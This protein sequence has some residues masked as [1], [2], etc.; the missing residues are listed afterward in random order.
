MALL[1]KKRFFLL[2]ALILAVCL[3]LLSWD[4]SLPRQTLFIEEAALKI[5][6]LPLRTISLFTRKAGSLV[7][8][9]V[10]LVDLGQENGVLREEARNL[11][12]DNRLLRIEAR[13]NDH[14]RGLL[15]LKDR[16]PA[17]SVAAEIIGED[18]SGWYKAVIIDKGSGSGVKMGS[19][20]LSPE[21]VAGRV[22]DLGENASKVL[23]VVDKNSSVDAM[24]ERTFGRGVVEGKGG[25]LC[26]L[27]Y[28]PSD[29]DIQRGDRVVTT[30]LGGV[31]P[32]GYPLGTVVRIVKKSGDLF[33]YVEV[34]PS[35]NFV[36]MGHVLVLTAASGG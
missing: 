24:I 14:L 17:P 21:G 30:G 28:V 25:Y 2:V 9:Y 29:E 33:Q 13:E 36:R 19:A 27:K 4:V 20:V 7:D 34:S 6:Y 35:V 22:F 31:F 15:G 26:E 12:L 1:R 3:I 5:L 10:M 8:S 23:L 32:K 11:R 18:P 16:A